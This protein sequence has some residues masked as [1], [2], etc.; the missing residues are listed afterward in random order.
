MNC[1]NVAL[2]T[3]GTSGIGE[4]IAIRLAADGF[5]VVVAGR[6]EQRGQSVV[7]RI[8]SDGGNA[9]FAV[10]DVADAESVASCVAFATA[11]LGGIDVLVNCAGVYPASPK[12]LEEVG[13][14]EW[15]RVI[16]VN[17]NG[18]FRVLRAVLP[19]ISEQHG[20]IVNV[21]SIGGLQSNVPNSSW[22]YSASKAGLIQLSSMLAKAYGGKLRVN[23]VC[24]GVVDTPIFLNRDFSRF[25]SQIPLG[26]VAQPNEIANVVSFLVS[27]D[28]SYVNG[29]VMVVDGGQSL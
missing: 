8:V 10:L 11:E 17:L 3:G 6:N 20:S 9:I 16:D 5:A 23:C 19:V 24:P 29:A 12:R 21:S 14:E 15:S 4:A 22:A 13:E 27:E 26:R 25:D 7:E 18:A 2:V 1:G 28:A